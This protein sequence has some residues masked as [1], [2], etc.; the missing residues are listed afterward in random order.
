MEG[1][2]KKDIIEGY[3]TS[4]TSWDEVVLNIMDEA[5]KKILVFGVPDNGYIFDNMRKYLEAQAVHVEFVNRFPLLYLWK[6]LRYRISG[7]RII[8]FNFV[9][10]YYSDPRLWLTVMKSILFLLSIY[11]LRFSGLKL[12]WTMHNS[13]PHEEFHPRL[14]RPVRRCFY[15][16]CDHIIVHGERQRDFTER[17][18]GKH[19]CMHVI[20]VGNVVWEKNRN[21]LLEFPAQ[22][23]ARRRLHLPEQA[24]VFLNFGKIRPYKNIEFLIEAF[25]EH[26]KTFPDSLLVIVGTP[27]TRAYQE[28]LLQSARQSLSI[29]FCFEY[30]SD[31]ILGYYLAA[32]NAVC[33]TNHMYGM[34]ENIYWAMYYGKPMI[35]GNIG[36]IGEIIEEQR[37]G[38]VY[39]FDSQASLIRT[40]RRMREVSEEDYFRMVERLKARKDMARWDRVAGAYIDTIYA[41]YF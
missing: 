19:R 39:K 14:T 13:L 4:Y 38:L 2:E 3:E 11:T 8:H 16:M 17:L 32:S 36:C 21:C 10:G 33:I 26:A 1:V 41:Q 40:L 27:V 25:L 22:E 20:P 24:Y 12:V 5:K 6:F 29:L 31:E 7:G 35:G 30:V 37:L 34:T 18:L 23:E 9:G 15:H 28:T